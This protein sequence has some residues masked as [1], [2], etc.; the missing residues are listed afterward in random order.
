MKNK[1]MRGLLFWSTLPCWVFAQAE[2]PS[3]QKN[4]SNFTRDVVPGVQIYTF[5]P[6]KGKMLGD[7]YLLEDWTSAMIKTRSSLESYRLDSVKLNLLND[8]IEFFENGRMKMMLGAELEEIRFMRPGRTTIAVNAKDYTLAEVPLAGFLE[9][10]EEGEVQLL[11]RVVMLIKEANYVI[12]L[13]VGSRS[14]QIVRENQYYFAEKGKL[15]PAERKKDIISYFD[16]KG[17]DIRPILKSGE[18]WIRDE[19]GLRKLVRQ[20]NQSRP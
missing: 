7:P 16:Q 3:A 17:F 13:N 1:F 9:K 4:A 6:G 18:V 15:F 8:R 14:D 10:L 19:E 12:A 2:N 11:K 5:D 20:Y